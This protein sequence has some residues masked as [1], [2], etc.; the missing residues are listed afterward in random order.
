MLIGNVVIKE[1]AD[2]FEKFNVT[3]QDE[4]IHLEKAHIIND[5]TLSMT[6]ADKYVHI[7]FFAQ[8]WQWKALQSAQEYCRK[9][10]ENVGKPHNAFRKP[11]T[12]WK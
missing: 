1:P 11:P 6:F 9:I 7:M 12:T 3:G 8:S 2:I 10:I 5:Y 4:M